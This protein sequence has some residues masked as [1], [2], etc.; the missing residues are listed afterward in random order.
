MTPNDHVWVAFM[1]IVGIFAY[2]VTHAIC[3]HREIEAHIARECR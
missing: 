1:F 3:G 2:S